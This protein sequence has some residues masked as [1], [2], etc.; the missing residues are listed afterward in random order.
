MCVLFLLTHSYWLVFACVC[1][2]VCL[3]AHSCGNSLFGSESPKW[4]VH[5]HRKNLTLLLRSS[6]V[7]SNQGPVY[8]GILYITQIVHVQN[9]NLLSWLGTLKSRGKFFFHPH[10]ELRLRQFPCCLSLLDFF[11][12][13]FSYVVTVPKTPFRKVLSTR[14]SRCSRGL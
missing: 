13:C 11:S 9:C 12:S 14:L 7:M 4:R 1:V 6:E 5:S 8:L 3:R 10:S 2:C